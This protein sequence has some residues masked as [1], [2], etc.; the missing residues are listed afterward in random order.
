MTAEYVAGHD[1]PSMTHFLHSDA[2]LQ[3]GLERLILA[4]PRLAPVGGQS[5][6]LLLAPA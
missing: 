6:R 1:K 2:D 3:A 4:D 5:R